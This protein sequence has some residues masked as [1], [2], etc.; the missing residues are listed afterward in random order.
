MPSN[1]LFVIVAVIVFAGLSPGLASAGTRVLSGGFMGLNLPAPSM[2]VITPFATSAMANRP[3]F[4]GS[5]GFRLTPQWRIEGELSYSAS[6]VKG[7]G[8]SASRMALMNVYYDFE[9]KSKWKPFLSLGAGVVTHDIYRGGLDWLS[10]ADDS[11]SGMAWQTG[12]GLNYQLNNDVSLSGGYRFTGTTSFD[13]KGYE[14][15]DGGHEVRFGIN[16][17][18]PVRRNRDV[19]E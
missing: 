17:K 11:Q 7:G 16:Y 14:F 1:R 10:I 12:G 15:D 18:L 13:D 9:T 6:A 4:A 8:E 5:L 19:P 2:P 3:S